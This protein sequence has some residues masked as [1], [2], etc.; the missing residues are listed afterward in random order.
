MGKPCD[1]PEVPRGLPSASEYVEDT[2]A[3]GLSFDSAYFHNMDD[4]DAMSASLGTPEGTSSLFCHVDESDIVG[5]AVEDGFWTT[6]GL[7]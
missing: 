6:G 2:G 4:F 3:Y 7:W 1:Q 5:H